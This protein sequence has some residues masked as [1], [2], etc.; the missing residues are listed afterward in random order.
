METIDY[1][2]SDI[3]DDLDFMIIYKGKVR[4][5][6][7]DSECLVE[8]KTSKN[9]LIKKLGYFKQKSSELQ[10]INEM[11]IHDIFHV[12]VFQ[13]FI[14]SIKSK[15]IKINQNNC[16]ELFELSLKYEY[17]EIMGKVQDFIQKRPD[18]KNLIDNFLN[19]NN[20]DDE[21]SDDPLKEEIISKNLDV[22]LKN[23][24]LERI[25]LKILIRILNSPQRVLSD[26]RLLFSF[27]IKKM[28]NCENE[29]KNII[30]ILPSCLDFT[31]MSSDEILEL[32]KNENYSTMFKPS[33]EDEVMKSILLQLKEID[34]KNSNFEEK[35]SDLFIKFSELKQQNE[36]NDIF[37][38]EM[39]RKLEQQSNII[40]TQEKMIQ[41]LKKANEKIEQQLI[42]MRDKL[43]QQ[44][45]ILLEYSTD[46]QKIDDN[47]KKLEIEI[48]NKIDEQNTIIQSHQ[49][50]IQDY[51]KKDEEQVKNRI[52][53][54]VSNDLNGLFHYLRNKSNIND[55]IKITFSS[56]VFSEIFFVTE[57]SNTKQYFETNHE[58]SPWICFEFVNYHI[59]PTSYTIRSV[60]TTIPDYYFPKS[61]IIEGSNSNTEWTNLDE[62]T[63]C[64]YLK[65]S[66]FVHTFSIQ[67]NDKKEF[68]FIK[69]R[70]TSKSW[71]KY[72]D[73]GRL[74]I[75]SIEFYGDLI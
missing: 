10:H 69:M 48:K 35:F 34:K 59:V 75:A 3:S 16:H 74:I 6:N 21:L 49:A 65:G 58:S 61:W 2:I 46:I 62:Q 42:E 63:D 15:H 54:P 50:I 40:N 24:Y 1:I 39:N 53:I 23:G 8:I 72:S 73:N 70:L 9:E 55:E 4:S 43:D 18:I 37:C 26:H 31:K 71:G 52:S 17:K 20:N 7:A 27:V 57:I 64:T 33:K 60:T 66:N 32:L 38:L 14:D 19:E 28:N 22:C 68:K 51:Q 13:E 30:E 41:D 67:N 25:P 56:N 45:K 12:D 29:D 44:E 11:Y 36:K 47:N 5:Q